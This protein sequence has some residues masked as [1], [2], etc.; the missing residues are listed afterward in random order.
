MVTKMNKS[1]HSTK[2]NRWMIVI[3]GNMYGTDN[4][5]RRI[6]KHKNKATRFEDWGEAK[7]RSECIEYENRDKDWNVKIIKCR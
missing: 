4:P 2:K 1:Y 3:N 6:T 7:W 5:D